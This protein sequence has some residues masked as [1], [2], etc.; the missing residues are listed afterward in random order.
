M[1]R[2]A[3]VD[4]LRGFAALAV[5]I[6]H[7]RWFYARYPNDWRDVPL[8]ADGLL[9]PVYGYGGMA[10][11]LFWILSGFVFAVAYGQYGKKLSA[12][13]FWLRR[14]SRLYPLHF[15]TL[16]IVAGLQAVS[17]YKFGTWQVYGNNDMHHFLL[18][19]F[20][21]SNWFSSDY[22]FNGPIWSVSIE[23]LVYI[24][25]LIYLKSAGLNLRAALAIC[26]A[27]LVL[28]GFTGNLVAQCAALFFGGVAFA[29]LAPRFPSRMPAAVI[30]CLFVLA[31]YVA[32]ALADL[33]P[34]IPA[35]LIYVGAPSVLLLFIALD[36]RFELP[37]QLHWIGA[38]TYA[39]YLLHMPVLIL[40]R[41]TVGIVPLWAFVGLVVALAVPT[42]Y[43]FEAP[44]QRWI[45]S[46]TGIKPRTSPTSV[47]A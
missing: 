40:L 19:L 32:L 24:G 18:Q 6:C 35:L 11:Q 20:L 2:Y 31:A 7:Y 3:Y 44:M 34:W 12:R 33:E 37:R 17:M 4:L 39:I 27:S 28:T 36:Y 9:W 41:M 43:W 5:L 26:A 15:A 25:F 22:S 10:V 14:F 1:K 29:I 23:E 21:A 38:S 8:P 45:R 46:R 16:L 13:E 47:M 42:Y 30:G